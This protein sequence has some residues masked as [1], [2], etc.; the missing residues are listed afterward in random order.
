MHFFK[1]MPE[2]EMQEV[3]CEFEVNKKHFVFLIASQ[4]SI[5]I[6]TG[7]T[8]FFLLNKGEIMLEYDE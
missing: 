1:A 6:L 7:E 4:L 5:C 8:F 2:F 3:V